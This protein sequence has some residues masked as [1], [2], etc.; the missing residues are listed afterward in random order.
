M[1]RLFLPPRSIVE[2]ITDAIR[3]HLY[4]M[5]MLRRILPLLLALPLLVLFSAC[6]GD[7]QIP[8]APTPAG[9]PTGRL[10]LLYLWSA[11]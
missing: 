8:A 11:P 1:V 6:S 2:T 5:H 10:T 3:R 4:P 7:E 9:L